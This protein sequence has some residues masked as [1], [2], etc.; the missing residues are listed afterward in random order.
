MATVTYDKASRFY[1][2]SERPAVDALDLKIDDGE[3][4]VLVGPSG[5][6]KSTGLRMLAGL[7][8][9]DEGEILIGDRTVTNLAPKDRD[10]AMVFQ[11]YALYPHM[12][13]GQNMGFA[14]KIAGKSKDDISARVAEAAKI[15]DLEPYLDRKPKALSGGQRQR[16]AMGRAIVRSPQVFLMDEPLSN[17]DAKLRVQTRTQIAALQ[18]RLGTTTVYVTHD[19]VEAMTMGDRVAVLRDGVLEQCDTPLRLYQEPTNVFVAGFIGSPGMNIAEFRI[20]NEHAVLGRA[21]IALT[22]AASS[23][24]AA[25]GAD[26]VIVGFR[27][28]SLDLVSKNDEGAFPVDVGVVEE[29]GSDAFLHGTLPELPEGTSTASGGI[30]ARVDPSRPPAKGEQVHLR[31]Q[32]GREHVFSATTGRRLPT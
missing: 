19:Q 6:G 30:I 24:L 15:L 27:P 25:E 9:V 12:T 5:S 11:S 29:L 13:V 31:I 4:L 22:R 20:E 17:L 21:R 2:G 26:R 23:A 10:I 1:P 7:E 28:E 18:R 3:F 16:V 14:L 8:D 32:P